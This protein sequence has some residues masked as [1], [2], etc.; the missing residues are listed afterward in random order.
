MSILPFILSILEKIPGVSG[1]LRRRP[2]LTLYDVKMYVYTC[3]KLKRS[4]GG[5]KHFLLVSFW[6][7]NGSDRANTIK[8]VIFTLQGHEKRCEWDIAETIEP[9]AA[10]EIN[11]DSDKTVTFITG[12]DKKEERILNIVVVDRHR[13]RYHTQITVRPS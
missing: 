6:I 5:L 9:H 7:K 13:R 1:F 2:K 10:L 12:E 8:K 4:A 3:D 11:N